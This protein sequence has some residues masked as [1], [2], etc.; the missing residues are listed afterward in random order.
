MRSQLAGSLLGSLLGVAL[1]HFTTKL[2]SSCS[3]SGNIIIVFLVSLFLCVIFPLEVL[4]SSV[5]L[6]TSSLSQLAYSVS[7]LS[8]QHN[9]SQLS[10]INLPFLLL[11][12]KLDRIY[13]DVSVYYCNVWWNSVYNSRCYSLF[14]ANS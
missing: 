4:N 8:Y 14:F 6:F 7:P 12:R 13:N 11:R 9:Y 2:L 5:Q 10:E 3:S 1:K